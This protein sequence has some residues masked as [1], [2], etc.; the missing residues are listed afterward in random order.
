MLQDF[1]IIYFLFYHLNHNTLI[2][3]HTFVGHPIVEDMACMMNQNNVKQINNDEKWNI[4]IL[5]GSRKVEIKRHMPI[6]HDFMKLF[7]QT[8]QDRNI[9]FNFLTLP[10]LR[11]FFDI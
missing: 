5:P 6:L 1:M 3:Y 8:H 9:I 4:A 7:R 11:N 10:H 2:V